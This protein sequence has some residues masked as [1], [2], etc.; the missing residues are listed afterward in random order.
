MYYS[1]LKCIKTINRISSNM[2]NK[3]IKINSIYDKDYII[4]IYND[5]LILY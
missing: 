2:N 1:N 3:K 5:N 4:I